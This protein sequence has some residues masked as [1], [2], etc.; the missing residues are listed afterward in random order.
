MFIVK[1]A[2]E[3]CVISVLF[4]ML[5]KALFRTFPIINSEDLSAES[6]EWRGERRMFSAIFLVLGVI[7]SIASF[8]MTYLLFGLLH[9][10][11]NY[12]GVMVISQGALIVP[13][14]DFWVLWKYRVYTLGLYPFIWDERIYIFRLP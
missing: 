5:R 12:E 13:S 3:L 1:F 7:L 14:T 10:I 11:G 2:L 6:R 9:S 4:L 8:W